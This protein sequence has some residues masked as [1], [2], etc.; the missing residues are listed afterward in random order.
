[1]HEHE[2][3]QRRQ[4]TPR[5]EEFGQLVLVVHED[6]RRFAVIRDVLALLRRAGR[7][8]AGRHRAGVDGADIRE[9]P[10]GTI[11]ADDGDAASGLGADRDQRSR[12]LT[13]LLVVFVPRNRLP[14]PVAFH[15]QRGSRSL[16]ANRAFENVHDAEL[17]GVA[18]CSLH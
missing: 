4:P 6:D 17:G 10:L 18:H 13:H 11:V 5:R 15:T 7:V 8:D 12:D 1:M 9:K 2:S 14:R 3:F 16:R